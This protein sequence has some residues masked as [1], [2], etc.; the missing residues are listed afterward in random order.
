MTRLIAAPVTLQVP[1]GT[2]PTS[3]KVREAVFSTLTAGFEFADARI[4]DLYAGTGALG[5]EALARGGE[6]LVAVEQA[7]GAVRLLHANVR[8]ALAVIGARLVRVEQAAVARWL[9]RGEQA[10]AAEDAGVEDAGA[11]EADEDAGAEEA[12]KDAG[13]GLAGAVAFDLVFIDPPYDLPTAVVR[14][15]LV[16]LRA[17]LSADALVVVERS[18]RSEPLDEVPGY[19]VWRERG[20]GETGVTYLEPVSA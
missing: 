7:A 20:Y 8:A 13:A 9:A 6:S 4:L 12:A 15:N 17:R 5:L 16:A 14:E 3:D 19:G 2:R 18:T 1:T 11:E 10:R